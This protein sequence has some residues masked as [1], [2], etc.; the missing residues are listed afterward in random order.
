VEQHAD[1]FPLGFGPATYGAS[2]ADVYDRWYS[3]ITD[4]G[5]TARFMAARCDPPRVLELGVG[6]GRLVDALQQAGLTVIGLDSSAAM[7]KASR[8]HTPLV[9]ADISAIPLRAGAG[10]G[11]ALCAFNTLFN[12]PTK[13]M[14][15]EVFL[16]VAPV[17]TG[18]LVVEAMT[19]IE[20]AETDTQSV[21]VSRLTADSLVLAATVID[22]YAQ[23]ITGQHVD[24]NQAGIQLRPW[25]LRWSTPAELD[26]MAERAGLE[27]AE[28]YSDW[29][30][31]PFEE[32]SE[33]H[34]SVYRRPAIN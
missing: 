9:I 3:S 33:T 31:T 28:R 32:Y 13:D 18:P 12:L 11:G 25:H 17:L 7:L 5:A 30:Q 24:I 27:L 4:A 26:E 2:F 21:G 10:I 1:R 19:G 29:D 14:Q 20:L 15:Q 22:H 6:T 34:V 16:Q 8:A 23:T